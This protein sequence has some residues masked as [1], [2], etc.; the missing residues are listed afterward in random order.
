[1]VRKFKI[2]QEELEFKMTNKT[3][4]DIDELYGNFGAVINGVMKN[5]NLYNNSARVVAC[6]CI[7][8]ELTEEELKEKLTPEQLTQDLVSFAI[9]IYLDYMGVK[10]SDDSDKDH[11]KK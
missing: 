3:I 2:G 9:Q 10:E 7:T 11:K 8:R 1:M 5:S 4:F 6:S